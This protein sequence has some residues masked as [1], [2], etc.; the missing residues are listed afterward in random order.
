MLIFRSREY[1][2][3]NRDKIIWLII[4][5][6]CLGEK[7]SCLCLFRWW[8]NTVKKKKKEEMFVFR[9]ITLWWFLKIWSEIRL[10]I[11]LFILLLVHDDRVLL[12]AS[13]GN[14]RKVNVNHFD[15]YYNPF[16]YRYLYQRK[17]AMDDLIW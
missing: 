6:V 9:S 1:T 4:M 17:Q 11:L 16:L 8:M 3:Q 5:Y 2:C 7:E 13:I 14:E 15:S 10:F 12:P